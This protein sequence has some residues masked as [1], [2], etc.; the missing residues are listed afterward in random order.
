MSQHA[1]PLYWVDGFVESRVAS[2]LHGVVKTQQALWHS[3][4]LDANSF[5]FAGAG[6]QLPEMLRFYLIAHCQHVLR[7]IGLEKDQ[8]KAF[9]IWGS[10]SD[11][12][13]PS[14]SFFHID[15]D[16]ELRKRTGKVSAPVAGA[17]LY[18][19]SRRVARGSGTFFVHESSIARTLEPY[20]F[21]ECDWSDLEP[22]L[23]AHGQAITFVPG[24][25][26]IFQ[27]ELA[28]AAIPQKVCT[29]RAT[30]TA[31][32]VNIWQRRPT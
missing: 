25:L 31:L 4:F 12:S 2:I 11:G 9:E 13:A 18:L 5:Q 6:A 17:I 21:Q 3:L 26:V 16:E 27:G 29:R 20:L 28:H 7:L 10:C 22:R 14:T 15:N 19:G 24:R 30:R 32:L 1:S 23:R 8:A